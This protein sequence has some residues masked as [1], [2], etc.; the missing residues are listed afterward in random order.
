M[1]QVQYT[2]RDGIHIVHTLIFFPMNYFPGSII[3][4]AIALALLCTLILLIPLIIF[5]IISRRTK[6]RTETEPIYANIDDN[7]DTE[8][9]SDIKVVTNE[10]YAMVSPN[11]IHDYGTVGKDYALPDPCNNSYT[12]RWK[13]ETDINEVE[14]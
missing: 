4:I 11:D 8:S 5:T 12:L 1:I 3:G 14:K 13:S 2:K 6:R 9:A 10:A 7:D